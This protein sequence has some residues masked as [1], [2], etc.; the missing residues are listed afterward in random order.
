MNQE[1][2]VKQKKSYTIIFIGI[3]NAVLFIVMIGYICIYAVSNKI[4][5]IDNGYNTHQQLLKEQNIRG[6]IYTSGGDVL[7]E[8]LIDENGEETRSYP[9]GKT[10]SH[11]VGF[12]TKGKSGIESLANYYLI[13]SN[14]SLSNKAKAYDKEEKFPG[15]SVYTTLDTTLQETAYEALSAHKGAIIVSEVKTG[16]ILAM[17]SKPDFDPNEIEKIW[18][19]LTSSNENTELLNRAT[20]GLY[21]PGSTFKIITAL[22]YYRENA[23][24]YLDYRYNCNGKFTYGDNTINCFH[25]ESHGSLDFAMSFAKSCNSS[26]ANIALG[27][28]RNSFES[29]LKSLLFQQELPWDMS[30]SK[31]VANCSKDISDSDIMQLGIGQGTTT[32]TPFHLNL[33]TNAVAGNGVLMKPRIMDRVVSSEGKVVE[34]FSKETYGKIMTEEEAAFLKE[35]MK[36]VVEEGT[37]S[38]LKGL[39]YTA[40]G[41][42][43]SAEFK[44]STSDSH[45]WF[46]GFAPVEDPQIS[47]TIIVENAGSGGEYAVPIAKRIFDKYFS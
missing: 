42:T 34:S 4:E 39:S 35:L 37:A 14:A 36:G 44:D 45:A 18:T 1:M 8:T 20:Q 19:D 12:A 31:S 11:I 5:M 17:V 10:F 32:M 41:K 9:Y 25:G 26:F 28:D 7:A 21:P 16:N 30:Y 46:T 29:T 13:N 40:A 3:F 47:V 38:K 23:D 33:I 43:G 2:P 6:T 22:E 27:L 15:D 24:S